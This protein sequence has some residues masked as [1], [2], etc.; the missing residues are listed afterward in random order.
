M[1]RSRGCSGPETGS[2]GSSRSAMEHDSSAA[3]RSN[4]SCRHSS[5]WASSP[6]L[7]GTQRSR[8]N[9]PG[10]SVHSRGN[11]T[12]GPATKFGRGALC[13]PASS[14]MS[15][16]SIQMSSMSNRMSS[17]STG[18]VT[19]NVHLHSGGE[20]LFQPGRI[21]PH[22]PQEMLISGARPCAVCRWTEGPFVLVTAPR[23][24]RTAPRCAGS[25]PPRRAHGACSRGPSD[26]CTSPRRSSTVSS[27]P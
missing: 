19:L 23:T 27:G 12:E 21:P 6:W 18:A 2:V 24:A 7:R 10:T 8:R 22:T 9:S 20:H 25:R 3:M 4:L 11:S 5:I 26:R 16:M 14:A 1:L 17:R 13:R 15:S